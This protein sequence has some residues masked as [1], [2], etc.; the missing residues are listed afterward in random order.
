M[1]KA[2][3]TLKNKLSPQLNVIK[4]TKGETTTEN[5]DILAK[6]ERTV[7]HCL[8][9]IATLVPVQHTVMTMSRT[10]QARQQTR[11]M[12]HSSL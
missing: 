12:K 7:K 3:R 1:Y 5:Y 2:I 6:M 8:Q 9:N 10:N 11:M 4:D